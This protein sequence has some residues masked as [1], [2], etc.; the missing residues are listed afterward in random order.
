MHPIRSFA[1]LTSAL[2]AAGCATIM[3]G[4]E[5][6]VAFSSS[7]SG[8]FVTVNGRAL[9][10]TPLLTD[11]KRRDTQMVRITMDGY[12]PYE[13]AMTRSVSGWLFGNILFGGIPG[14][15]VDFATG[16]IYKLSPEQVAANLNQVTAYNLEDTLFVGV[17]LGAV[18]PAW[19]K[20]ATM[21]RE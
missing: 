16:S 2:L 13:M 10:T 15:I 8:A 21:E 17:T 1:V 3:Q 18:D 20:V 14:L 7:P 4:S 19:E 5:Q 12:A 9:G 6:G 11:L